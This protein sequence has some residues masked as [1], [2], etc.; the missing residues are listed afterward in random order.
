MDERLKYYLG[1]YYNKNIKVEKNKIN[2]N[3]WLIVGDKKNLINHKNTKN[4]H[5]YNNYISYILNLLNELNLNNEILFL[6]GDYNLNN[7]NLPIIS[8][9]RKSNSNNIIF[10]FNKFRH[11]NLVYYLQNNKDIKF[12]QKKNIICWR[13]S[14]TGNRNNFANRFIL[15]E[16]YY[17][18]K[19]MNIG[20]SSNSIINNNEKVGI[21]Q[22][23]Y[24]YIEKL[25]YIKPA[26]KINEILKYK[27]LISVEGNDVA[28]GLKWMLYSNSV[29]LMARPRNF[30]WI[31]EDKLIPN[32]HFILL[33]D[34][35][36][37]LNEKYEWCLKNLDKCEDISKNA[38]KY[39]EQFLDKELEKK[40]EIE[41][42]KR[43]C[44]NIEI[45]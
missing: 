34:D 4:Y 11:M 39:I 5:L 8:K 18:H 36:S 1:Q 17:N 33:K 43:Y 32:H 29:V 42:I 24:N 25:K 19:N 37:D 31:M 38:T 15:V 14:T 7:Q 41:I 6:I 9:T 12:N 16:N 10:N 23:I 28:S 3:K 27:F 21:T 35:Y 22:N 44:N 2:F 45:I 13:G 26:M 30:S 20:F 40:I